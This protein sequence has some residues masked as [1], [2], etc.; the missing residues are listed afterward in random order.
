MPKQPG[1][2]ERNIIHAQ[3]AVGL[4][5]VIFGALLFVIYKWA[6]LDPVNNNTLGYVATA[7][8]GAGVAI[9]PAT[10]AGAASTRILTGQPHSNAVPSAATGSATAINGQVK[11]TGTVNTNGSPTTYYFQYGRTSGYE[12]ATNPL[13]AAA[14]HDPVPVE[15]VVAGDGGLHFR[16]VAHSAAGSAY[17]DDRAT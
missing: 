1:V 9:L 14:G 10:A 5:L 12:A 17:G 13:T 16:I 15:S 7:I 3:F 8:I 2:R 11:L 6:G 4:C